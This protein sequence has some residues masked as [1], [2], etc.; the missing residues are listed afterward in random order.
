[1]KKLPGFIAIQL[2]TPTAAL[3]A[4][5]AAHTIVW[6]HPPIP[7]AYWRGKHR[8]NAW[9]PTIVLVEVIVL[10]LNRWRCPLSSVAARYTADRRANFDSYVPEMFAKQINPSLMRST[11]KRHIAVDTQRLPHAIA[12]TTVNVTDRAGALEAHL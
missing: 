2:R 9:L 5:K 3:K 7:F 8:D 11:I 12:V 10:L 6:L 4:I 1:M